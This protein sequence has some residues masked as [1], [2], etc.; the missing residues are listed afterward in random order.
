MAALQPEL[1]QWNIDLVDICYE[2]RS[3]PMSCFY[4]SI[5]LGVVVTAVVI[6]HPT[7]ASPGC[8]TFRGE[9]TEQTKGEGGNR[10]GA[11]F[12]KD[13]KLKVTIRQMPS[14]MALSANLMK[15][16]DPSG[17]FQAVTE[18]VSASFSY[19]VPANTK[20]FIYLNFSGVLPGQVITWECESA[21]R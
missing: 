1:I 7:L 20:D 8:S 17:P 6:S 15:Y 12:S 21:L 3:C 2:E 5:V 14:Q 10:V 16:S 19:I 18:D 13:D 11:G 4:N 9:V